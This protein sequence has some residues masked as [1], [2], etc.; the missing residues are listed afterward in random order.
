MTLGRFVAEHQVRQRD[1]D[2]RGMVHSARYHGLCEDAFRDWL[3]VNG[4]PYP[5]LRASGVDIVIAESTY[6]YCRS[7]RVGDRLQVTVMAETVTES[8]L[9]ARFNVRR[10]QELVTRADIVYVAA[11]DGL[12][13]PLPAPLQRLPPYGRSTPE[14]ILYELHEAQARL[15]AKGD[16]SAVAQ[17]LDPDVVWRVP[18]SN[19]IAGTYRGVD[20]VVAYMRRRRELAD[21]TFRMRCREV[22][23]GPSHVA[24]LTDGT[25][26]RDGTTYRWSTIGLYRARDGRITECSLIPLDAA[27]FD[28]AWS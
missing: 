17:L 1:C 18:G 13:C 26:E 5:T 24:A 9:A 14:P 12:H 7:A 3:E 15:Y 25:V 8:R 4:M 6:C 21:A 20:E 19:R 2:S 28:A 22:L 16:A 23:M 27:A 10:G 11:T